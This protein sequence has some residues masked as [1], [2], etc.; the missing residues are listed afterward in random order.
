MLA[1]AIG[2]ATLASPALAD[3]PEV[4][5]AECAVRANELIDKALRVL[6]NP[7]SQYA[8]DKAKAQGIACGIAK[9][10]AQELREMGCPAPL[11]DSMQEGYENA[12]KALDAIN[13][14]NG[15]R[16]RCE[17]GYN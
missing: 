6:G 9:S 17:S 2:F 3:P 13:Q 11:V 15:F 12:K 5:L 16:Y 8:Q 10:G 1:A 4:R 14:R 7:E